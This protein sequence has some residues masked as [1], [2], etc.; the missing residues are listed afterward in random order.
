[1]CRVATLCRSG[2]AEFNRRSAAGA[3]GGP[4]KSCERHTVST[5]DRGNNASRIRSP[6]FIAAAVEEGL[7]ERSQL[8]RGATQQRA[9]A[10]RFGQAG[11]QLFLRDLHDRTSRSRPPRLAGIRKFRGHVFTC[12][13]N[14]WSGVGRNPDW[15]Q[16]R[17]D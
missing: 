5:L 2:R 6:R 13:V 3:V 8:Q 15:D 16:D 1:M 9:D 10:I 7:T 12:S 11:G 17:C 14:C 4:L